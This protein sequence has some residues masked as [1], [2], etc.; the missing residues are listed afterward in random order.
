MIKFSAWRILAPL[1]VL[2]LLACGQ[3]PVSNNDASTASAGSEASAEITRTLSAKLEK[4][5]QGQNLKVL[6]V[7]A[8][9]VAGLYE[10][11][12]TGNQIVYVDSKANYML[13]GDLLDI[14]TRKSLTEARLSEINKI[15]FAQL[16][17]E[18]AIKEVRGNGRQKIAVFADPDCPFC[19]KLEEEFEQLTDV[20]I[21]TFLMPIPSLHPQ[22]EPKSV[23]IWCQKDRVTAW[24]NW[25]RR[26]VAPP[27][28][29][30]CP[31]P[32][33]QTMALGEK[34]GFNGTPTVIFPNGKVQSGYMDKA[35]LETA[36]KESNP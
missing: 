11:L 24:T 23:Q 17:L 12:V 32:V 8:T 3:T 16:P 7:N 27:T 30:D 21:Y 33:A 28:V 10:V 9:P 20:T 25:M 36:L 31:N 22:A 19:K 29:A 14:N 26:N 34:F 6:S 4:T 2:P 18:N 13:V 1:C 35:A 5:Y 15:D